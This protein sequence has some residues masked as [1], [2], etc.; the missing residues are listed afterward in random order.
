MNIR[1]W[2]QK[3]LAN[4]RNTVKSCF[5]FLMLSFYYMKYTIQMPLSWIPLQ[6]FVIS[7]NVIRT[8]KYIP[9]SREAFSC[10]YATIISIS[11]CHLYFLFVVNKS[12]KTNYHKSQF[13]NTSTLSNLLLLVCHKILMKNL[14]CTF[15]IFSKSEDQQLHKY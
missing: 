4:D 7:F 9:I 14:S 8:S 15:P 10:W 3:W 6:C 13:L 11:T 1:I 2:N 5:D 12:Y